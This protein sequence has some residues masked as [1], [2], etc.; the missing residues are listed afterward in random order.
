MLEQYVS[1]EVKEICEKYKSTGI[2]KTVNLTF[3]ANKFFKDFKR[4]INTDRRGEVGFVLKRPNGKYVVVRSKRYPKN[5]YR[6]PTGGINF[7]E[8]ALDALEREVKEELG[9]KFV[10]NEFIGLLE[11]H[12]TNKKETL[13]FYS[14]LF[15]IDEKGGE[16]LKDATENEISGIREM[17]RDELKKLTLEFT[18]NEFRWKDWSKFRLQ[19][20]EFFN[21]YL[22]LK[23]T[24]DKNDKI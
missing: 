3:L 19:L 8:T 13:K 7:Q 4:T 20:L 1:A 15:L 11:Y 17:D 24:G 16:I 5:T 14:Y 6:I 21:S 18:K 10:I 12:I 23:E 22:E 2:V 9:V